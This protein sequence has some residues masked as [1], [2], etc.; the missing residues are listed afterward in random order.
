[1]GSPNLAKRIINR[2]VSNV[3]Y[4]NIVP[5]NRSFRIPDRNS[6]D[7]RRGISYKHGSDETA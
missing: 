4:K 3:P 1:M 5:K 2:D 6:S 7:R